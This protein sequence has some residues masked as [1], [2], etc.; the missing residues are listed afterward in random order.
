MIPSEH[1]HLPI[2]SAKSAKKQE[3]TKKDKPP[4]SSKGKKPRAPSLNRKSKNSL[5]I[6]IIFQ[7]YAIETVKY[8]EQIQI[9]QELH[10]AISTTR[11]MDLPEGNRE[12]LMH[13]KQI[14]YPFV[15]NYATNKPSASILQCLNTTTP[16]VSEISRI[17][18]IIPS[19]GYLEP[20]ESQFLS[21]SYRPMVN[22]SVKARVLCHV[23]G[24]PTETLD[25]VGMASDISYYL[26]RTSVDFGRQ[27]GVLY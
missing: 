10:E 27:V 5:P 12:N 21:L 23:L 15:E 20:F 25:I 26:N 6:E 17:I 18:E 24:G 2:V 22:T 7:Q 19:R 14:L 1:E 13:L 11:L 3:K 16:R 9:Y 4:K 8:P